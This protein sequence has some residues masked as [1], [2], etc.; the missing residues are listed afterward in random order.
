MRRTFPIVAVLLGL[1][2]CAA[3]ETQRAALPPPL[4]DKVTPLPY[5]TLLE[6]SRAQVKKATE[7]FYVDNWTDLD[8]AARGL[9][10]TAQYLAKAEDVPAKHKD[11]L[12]TASA[13]L[14]K[15]AGSLRKAA[16]D[17]DVKKTTDVLT[18]IQLQVREMRLSEGL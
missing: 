3:P 9:E 17:K 13:D 18:K 8:E 4:P 10:Q 14:G 6:R 12:V 11:T 5:S 16:G 7:A 15:L 2:G 1:A